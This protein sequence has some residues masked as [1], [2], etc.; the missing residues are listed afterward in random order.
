MA[1]FLF[2][3]LFEGNGVNSC[4]HVLMVAVMILSKEVADLCIAGIVSIDFVRFNFQSF[5]HESKKRESFDKLHILVFYFISSGT[6][7]T[8]NRNAT[9]L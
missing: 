7:L 9:I 5:R 2:L 6:H 1:L 8:Q 4:S 3:G